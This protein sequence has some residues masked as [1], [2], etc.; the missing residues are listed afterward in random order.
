VKEK[1][2]IGL[3]S[4]TSLDGLDIAYCKFSKTKD[5]TF[6]ILKERTIG[7]RADLKDRLRNAP[8][9]SEAQIETLSHDFGVFMAEQVNVFVN[10]HKIHRLDLIASHG[11][12]VFHQPENRITLQIGDVK[13]LFE[14]IQKP[15]V[16]D[17]RTQDVL[18]GGQGAPLVP[19]VDKLLFSEYDACLNLGGFSNISFDIDG[20]RIAFDICP[21]NIVLNH[22]ANMLGFEFD[23]NGQI[24]SRA[25]VDRCLLEEFNTIPYYKESFP[26]SLGWEW[27]GEFILP[28]LIDS[29]LSTETIMRTFVEHIAIQ[30]SSIINQYQLKRVLLSG[31]GAYNA[32]LLERISFFAPNACV[33]ANA[34][35]IESKEA[36]AFAFLGL[37][38]FKKEINVLASVTGSVKSH[39]SGVVYTEE[40]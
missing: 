26:K 4:G 36:M 31:G 5:W 38:R 15:V 3:M 24:A 20:E 19:I 37:L 1:Y 21:V 7:Y 25:N 29:P 32:F 23:D 18:L 10:D 27:V 40:L 17:F 34:Q 9:L 16:Y 11:H 8:Q 2:V 12:T 13:P 39:S 33:I 30:I 14:L 28:H 22:L 6:E 35:L